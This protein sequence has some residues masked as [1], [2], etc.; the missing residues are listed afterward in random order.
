MNE[1]VPFTLVCIAVLAFACGPR[2]RGES[3]TDRSTAR[4]AAPADS[5]APLSPSLDVSVEDGVRFAFAVRND[6]ARKLEVLFPDGRTHDV[7]VLD[8]LGREVWRWSE[9]RLF[10]QAVQSR[11]VRASDTLRFEEA[12]RDAQPG[13]YVA[14]A[15][16]ASRNYPVEQRVAFTVR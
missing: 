1:K 13:S 8:S 3:A 16:L 10:T 5:R 7:V 12:W 2:P 9:G 14:V 6:G 11:V 15:T 4:R